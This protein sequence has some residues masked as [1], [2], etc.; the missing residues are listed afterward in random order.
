MLRTNAHHATASTTTNM[1]VL[2]RR[3]NAPRLSYVVKSS[4]PQF[5]ARTRQGGVGGGGRPRYCAPQTSQRLARL[6][7]PGRSRCEARHLAMQSACT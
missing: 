5:L 3:R 6:R 1:V 7:P 2:S 4:S